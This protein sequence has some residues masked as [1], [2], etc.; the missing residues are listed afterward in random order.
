MTPAARPAHRLPAIATEPA[1][2]AA[3]AAD[4]EAAGFTVERLDSLWGTEAA[5]S[6]HRGSR[7]A[8]LRAL[9]SRESSPL[10]TLATLFVLGLPVSRAH[11]DAAFPSAGV[12]RVVAAGLLRSDTAPETDTD[13][14]D[15]DD[16][17]LPLDP[18]DALVHPTVDLRPYAFVDDLG[19][20]SW[21]I[22]SDLG[23][24]ALGTALGE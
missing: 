18:A 4:L 12:D 21:W 7:V 1:A 20:G 17:G 5:A 10:A 11:A 3:I 2:V 9:A 24:L 22:V 15:T 14:A 16:S 6:L 13:E 8:A 19:A 23:E